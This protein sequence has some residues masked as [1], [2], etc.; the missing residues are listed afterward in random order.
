MKN[1]DELE[2][3]LFYSMSVYYTQ[4]FKTKPS[5][6]F[7]LSMNKLF[8]AHYHLRNEIKQ[9]FNDYF[10]K[11]FL[12]EKPVPIKG[13]YEVAYVYYYKNVKSDLL[14][15]GSFVSKVLLDALQKAGVVEEDNVKFCVKETF[16]VGGKDKDNPRMDIYIRKY[17]DET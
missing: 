1:S 3:F 9:H 7:L 12:D 2:E 14:N 6:T 17:E 11:L 4:N 16:L 15:V 13:Q 10:M 8:T 5:K